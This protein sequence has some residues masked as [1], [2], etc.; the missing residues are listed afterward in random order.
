MAA[1]LYG[2]RAGLVLSAMHESMNESLSTLY[3]CGN[4]RELVL[5]LHACLCSHPKSTLIAAA[6]AGYLKGFPGLTA[7]AISKYIKI[8]HATEAGHMTSE[9]SFQTLMGFVLATRKSYEFSVGSV[10][11]GITY[12]K[13]I[14]AIMSEK[15]GVCLF[16]VRHNLFCTYTTAW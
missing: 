5:Y 7:D 9:N 4:M 6:K 11:H 10:C 15:S 13:N 16:C 14:H 2:V 3:Q 8:E 12:V 1:I